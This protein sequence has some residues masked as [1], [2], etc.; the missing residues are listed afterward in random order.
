MSVSSMEP[1]IDNAPR[2]LNRTESFN[3]MVLE[4][5]DK[6]R[7]MDQ[8]VNIKRYALISYVVI[9]ILSAIGIYA[10]TTLNHVQ[11][12]I[13]NHDYSIKEMQNRT[14]K[15]VAIR[16]DLD[17]M[18]Q[19]LI[20]L[21]NLANSDVEKLKVSVNTQIN[22]MNQKFGALDN[23]KSE[24]KINDYKTRHLENRVEQ[25]LLMGIFK[26]PSENEKVMIPDQLMQNSTSNELQNKSCSENSRL[27]LLLNSTLVRRVDEIDLQMQ[28]MYQMLEN[29]SY[30]LSNIPT[31]PRPEIIKTFDKSENKNKQPDFTNITGGDTIDMLALVNEMRDSLDKLR[32][33]R[34]GKYLLK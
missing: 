11:K 28:D 26:G 6:K 17:D 1:I 9:A 33:G 19:S 22:M 30:K 14:S 18:H 12:T 32:F 21:L 13:K 2:T 23:V 15:N 16:K 25:I 31:G 3:G 8:L 10:V 7:I 24:V 29:N 27:I 5:G 20:N 4:D 34:R